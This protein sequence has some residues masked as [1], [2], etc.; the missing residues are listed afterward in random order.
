MSQPDPAPANPHQ[1]NSLAAAE[2]QNKQIM[3][4]LGSCLRESPLGYWNLEAG[5][6]EA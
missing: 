2:E 1:E 4:L 3:K 6:L 5:S